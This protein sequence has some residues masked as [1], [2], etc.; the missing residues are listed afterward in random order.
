MPQDNPTT[1]MQFCDA[2][3]YLGRISNWLALLLLL[4]LLVQIVA[5]VLV[6]F[7]GVLG[8]ADD[9]AVGQADAETWSEA[10]V[11]ATAATK[12]LAVVCGL[13]L[14][15]TVM[16]GVKVSL[17]GQVGE[18][19]GFL[20]AFFWSLVLLA[21]L[22]P[23]Q[24]IL[25]TSLA[26]GATFNLSQLREGAE[27][28]RAKLGASEETVTIWRQIHYFARFLAYPIVA[29]FM[30]LLVAMKFK[31]GFRPLKDS[32]PSAPVSAGASPVES[33]QIE[34]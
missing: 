18:T 14:M 5:F 11:F 29:M 6:D 20:G 23:W 8:A 34:I 1:P 15:L 19:R 17:V 31:R 33:S 27:L 32:P 9:T 16:F 12:F 3:R 2:L 26:S 30:V 10:L 4:C 24:Q 13:L 28:A 7:V 21:M 22:V 25:Y